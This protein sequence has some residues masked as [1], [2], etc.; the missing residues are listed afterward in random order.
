M[1]VQFI[2]AAENCDVA[3]FAPPMRWLT[4]DSGP[5][6]GSG[7]AGA[8][9]LARRGHGFPGSS[10]V[11]VDASCG[12]AAP[13]PFLPADLVR[14]IDALAR[15]LEREARL[16]AMYRGSLGSEDAH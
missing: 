13:R 7:L 4:P 6:L 2:D 9:R 5:P 3:A 10:E 14:I 15:R 8:C 12:R 11:T 1:F 16:L